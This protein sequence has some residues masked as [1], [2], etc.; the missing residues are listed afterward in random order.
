MRRVLL[1]ALGSTCAAACIIPPLSDL[2]TGACD[3]D[4]GHPCVSGACVDGV[5]VTGSSGGGGGSASG[6]GGA[7]GGGSA[8]GGG[9]ATG[10]GSG[11]TSDGGTL[12]VFVTRGSYL[13]NL[14]T[15][16]DAGTGPGGA[17]VL[18]NLSARAGG[19][20]GTWMAFV[21]GT[22][23]PASRFTSG[24]QWSQQLADGG[25][26][27]TF[28]SL[29][30]GNPLVPI[31]T[32]EL[33]GAQGSTSVW[34]GTTSDGGADSATCEGFTGQTGL[35]TYGLTSSATAGWTQ[36]GSV[37]CSTLGHLYCFEQD[38]S[39]AAPNPQSGARSLFITSSDFDGTF[40]GLDGGDAHCQA[41]ASDA[42]LAGSHLAWLSSQT[43]AA[44]GRFQNGPP[45]VQ[46]YADGGSAIAFPN[47]AALATAPLVPLSADEHGRDLGFTA[48][49][50]ATLPG[51]RPSGSDCQGFSTATGSATIGDG[52]TTGAWT[53]AGGATPCSQRWHLLCLQQ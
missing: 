15:E 42:G 38:P 44:A 53:A 48:Y 18:C 14:S 24:G 37:P 20:G 13:G 50:T 4:A 7:T 26:V 16:G 1:A 25:L 12:R 23:A 33:G 40:G 41:A 11:A 9:A 46:Q 32:D 2:G 3:L 6:G 47:A 10:G 36:T 35:G 51:G 21:S 43:V 39:P 29:S 8:A 34:T 52:L 17:D 31:D 19:K 30:Q 28:T 49:W 5:C 27:L 22:A 45:W